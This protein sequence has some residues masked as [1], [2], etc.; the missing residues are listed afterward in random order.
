MAKTFNKNSALE[1][2]EGEAEDTNIRVK[3]KR[4]Q[5]RPKT[6][7]E[8]EKV[9]NIA[10]PESI[11]DQLDIAKVCYDNNMTKYINYLIA[12]DLEE[13]MTE[14]KKAYDLLNKF[15]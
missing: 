14:Y 15:R 11:S 6:K 1:M 2:F 4:K 12:K 10:V 9:L 5:G 8:P 7:T 13:N 3:P